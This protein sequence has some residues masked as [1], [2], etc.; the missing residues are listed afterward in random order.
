MRIP[1]VS[2]LLPAALVVAACSNERPVSADRD[3]TL[4]PSAESATAAVVSARE[5]GL[6]EVER[7]RVPSTLSSRPARA[8]ARARPA[9][10]G[11]SLT[12]APTPQPEPELENVADAGA[13]HALA[14][15]Q[16]V[17]V[18]PATSAAGPAPVPDHDFASE[19]GMRSRPIWVVEGDDRCIPGRGEV[20]P[21][22]PGGFHGSL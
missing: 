20:I 18:I 5:L 13:G 9:A 2:L 11:S 8:R 1:P 15:G 12:P 6:P 14:P 3:L 21:R 17:S 7:S 16:S 22:R 19:R 4:A 10:D